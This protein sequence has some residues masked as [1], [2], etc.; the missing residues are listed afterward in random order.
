M[1]LRSLMLAT[2]AAATLNCG[3]DSDEGNE[4]AFVPLVDCNESFGMSDSC[5][6]DIV[7]TWTLGEI[8][9]NDVPSEAEVL[10]DLCPTATFENVVYDVSGT[11][12]ADGTTFTQRLRGT[13]S[14]DANVPVQCLTLG[15]FELDCAGIQ[16]AAEAERGISATCVDGADG[17]CDCEVIA[18]LAISTSG[19]YTT[20]DALLN[21]SSGEESDSFY[22]CVEGNQLTLRETEISSPS[23]QPIFA[24]GKP[25]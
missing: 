1:K 17:G 15:P 24:L 19:P 21:V 8:C 9:G 7:G 6:G 13:V 25:E 23:G 20:G 2:I 18:D 14:G 4:P 3:S 16:S 22:Y 5:G 12:V 11:I 10:L